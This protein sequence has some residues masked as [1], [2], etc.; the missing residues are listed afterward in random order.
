MSS[1]CRK[2]LYNFTKQKKQRKV[3]LS[4][5]YRQTKMT[6][7]EN[8][9]LWQNNFLLRRNILLFIASVSTK[10]RY[11]ECT[12]EFHSL[13]KIVLE[14]KVCLTRVPWGC[15]LYGGTRFSGT[16]VILSGKNIRLIWFQFSFLAITDHAWIWTLLKLRW[17]R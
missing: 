13:F 1:I 12:Y 7:F 16:W 8:C 3:Y 6:P 10:T 2:Q 9:S 5:A 11:P 14:I 17:I 4:D 15:Y